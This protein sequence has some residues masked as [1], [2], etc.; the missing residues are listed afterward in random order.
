MIGN[1]FTKWYKAIPLPD[2]QASTTANALLEH[3][4]CRFGCP[5]II[6]MDQERDFESALFEQLMTLLEIHKTRTT[7]SHPQSNSIID[8][9]KR[10]LLNMLTK[11][12]DKQQ[13][14][15]A[16][17]LPFVL[18]AYRSSVRNQPVSLRT[19]L[20]LDIRF[21]F[22]LTCCISLP[23]ATSQLTSMNMWWNNNRKFS[24]L[25]N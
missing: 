8:R 23:K 14:N 19:D 12:I 11:S 1:H 5:N 2:Q 24:K 3:W 4:I 22:L 9:M 15:W 16:Y 18:M 20:S 21:C 6:H 17:F 13:A 25:P 7:S 10:T